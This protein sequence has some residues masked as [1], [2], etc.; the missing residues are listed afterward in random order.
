[1]KGIGGNLTGNIQIRT[2]TLNEIGEGELGWKTVQSLKG[3]LDYMAGNAANTN[4]KSKIEES[5]HVFVADYVPLNKDIKEENS[6]ML[7]NGKT[8]DILLIDD[9]MELH[10][11]LEIYLKYTGGQNG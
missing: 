4:F 11:Q 3:W 6:Q 10:E 7:I 2:T 1:M 5:T 9:P 8:Y